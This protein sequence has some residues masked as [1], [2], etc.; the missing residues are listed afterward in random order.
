MYKKIL[1]CLDGSNL[2]E[3]ILPYAEEQALHFNSRLTLIRVYAEPGFIGLG[4]PG[5]PGVPVETGRTGAVIEKEAKDAEEYLKKI[6]QRIQDERGLTVETVSLLGAAGDA[7]V[8]YAISNGFD[9]IAIATHGR[10]GPGRAVM[11]SVA[12]YVLRKSNLP[13]LL[14]RP[15]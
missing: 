8:T 3:Q 12:D 5:F 2:A 6:S 4:V 14:I 1:V 15:K 10:S 13:I 9:M 7:I 11:G